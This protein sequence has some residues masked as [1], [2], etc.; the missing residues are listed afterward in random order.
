MGRIQRPW[1]VD[2]E[3]SVNVSGECDI[4]RDHGDIATEWED[5]SNGVLLN[6][7]FHV[8]LGLALLVGTILYQWNCDR[9]LSVTAM[10]MRTCASV[11]YLHM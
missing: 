6:A 9:D 4:D 8:A 10:E 1:S 2:R 3:D 11:A 7:E 5:T